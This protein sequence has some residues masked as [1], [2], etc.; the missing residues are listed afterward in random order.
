[1]AIVSTKTLSYKTQLLLNFTL[2]FILFTAVLVAFQLY[3]EKNH[4]NELLTTRLRS[5]ADIV[6]NEIRNE[7]GVNDSTH[8]TQVQKVLQPILPQDLRLTVINSEGNVLL[9]TASSVQHLNNHM[10]RPEVIKTLTRQEGSDIRR[11]ETTGQEYFYYAKSFDNFIVRVALPYNLTTKSFLK[12]DNITLWFIL[13]IFPVA[14]TLLIRVSDR[15]GQ[16]IATLRH[17]IDSAERGLIDYEHIRFP[18]SELGDIGQAILEKYKQT[19]ESKQIIER[20]RER[21]NRHFQHFEEGIAI[22]SADRHKLYANPRFLQYANLLL[23]RPTGDIQ[24]IWENAT[25]REALHFLEIHQGQHSTTA[26]APIYRTTIATGSHYL[27][28]Q[29]LVYND[30]SFEITLTDVT[31]AEKNRLLKQQMSNNITHELRTPVSS[32]RGYLETLLC[33]QSLSEEKRNLFL[34]RAHRQSIRLTDLIRDVSIIT[35]TE[36]APETMLRETLHIEQIVNEIT[37]ELRP[38]IEEIGF[39]IENHLKK[40]LTIHG[41]YSLI[42]SIFRNLLDNSL[43]YAGG[44][45]RIRIECYNEDENYFYFR[46]YDT[47]LGV[48]SQHLPRLFERFYRASEGRTRKGTEGGTGL[49]LSIVRNAILF[50]G[51]D[52]S[53]RNRKQGGLEFLF[54]LKKE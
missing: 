7:G 28:L 3:R 19:E 10:Q 43:H 30:R 49:G 6:A 13:L 12:P 42:Y 47:G 15:F 46:Y 53:V 51:G 31:R 21:L 50:H 16:S 37:E 2:I 18:S 27:S 38:Q 29:L 1:M 22:F 8:Y 25:F 45:C 35:K 14:L 11:S 5:C 41:N 32:I 4:R 23:D 9:E 52:I 40:K 33:C 48:E 39:N 34:E 26:E 20:E 36:E 17:F 24:Q 54:T 44:P